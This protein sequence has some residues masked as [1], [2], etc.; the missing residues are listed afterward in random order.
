MHE[1]RLMQ[2]LV[3]HIV[4]IADAEGATRVTRV[5]V[6]LGAL[7]HFTP[8][9]FREHYVDA[10]RGTAA[11]GAAVDARLATDPTDA[12]AQDVVLLDVELEVP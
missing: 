4:A 6:E 9:H 7:S 8:D 10:T 12:R 1:Q 11:A 5:T 3:G 2:D